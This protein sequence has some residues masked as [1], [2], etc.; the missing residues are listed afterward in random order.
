MGRRIVMTGEA[1]GETK[2]IETYEYIFKTIEA[3]N[4]NQSEVGMYFFT[5]ELHKIA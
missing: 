5:E 4:L 1:E 3:L 2:T